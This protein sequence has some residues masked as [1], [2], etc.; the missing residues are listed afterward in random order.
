MTVNIIKKVRS[1]FLWPLSAV[2]GMQINNII[3]RIIFSVVI[4]P[5]HKNTS[6]WYLFK[7]VAKS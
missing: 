7:N 2:T 4:K 1:T 6:W 5:W 3:K